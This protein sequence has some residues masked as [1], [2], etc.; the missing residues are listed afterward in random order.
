GGVLLLLGMLCGFAWFQ[1]SK[2]FGKLIE[3]LRRTMGHR[4]SAPEERVALET[5]I[6]RLYADRRTFIVACSFRLA[7]WLLGAFEVWLALRFMGVAAGPREALV[8][9]S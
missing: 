7:A 4:E 5:A 9:E 3:R 2:L 6:G 1:R 8:L